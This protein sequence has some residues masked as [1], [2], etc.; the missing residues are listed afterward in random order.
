MLYFG[1]IGV[2]V[3]SELFDYVSLFLYT[4]QSFQWCGTQVVRE[5]SAKLL[6]AGSIPART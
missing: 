6:F 3:G 2:I 4:S 5:Q 1:V